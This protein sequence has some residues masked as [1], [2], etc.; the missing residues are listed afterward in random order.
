MRRISKFAFPIKR[1]LYAT[2]T[3]KQR[4]VPKTLEEKLEPLTKYF[5]HKPVPGQPLQLTKSQLV[6]LL[7]TTDHKEEVAL[8]AYANTVTEKFYGKKIFFRGIIELSNVCQKNCLYCGIR[9]SMKVHRYTMT[10]E[11]IIEQAMWAYE[12]KYGSIVLQSGELNTPQRLDMII[13]IIKELKQ[14]TGSEPGK[15]LGISLSLGEMSKEDYQRLYDAGAHRYLLRIETSNPELYAKL[16]PDDGKHL[17]T[18]RKQSLMY[19]KEIGYQVGT[20]VM[21]M[22]PGQTI[23]DLAND[24]LFFK[25]MDIDMIG[26][27]PYICQHDTPI[28]K[29]WLEQN[30]NVNMKEYNKRLFRMSLKMIAL[31]RIMLPDVNIAATTAL[32]AINPTG[33][34]IAFNSGANM[35]MPILTPK[36]YRVD[37]QLYEG[38]PCVD[39]TEEECKNCLATRIKYAGK[40]LRLDG[41]W[42]DPLHAKDRTRVWSN[43]LCTQ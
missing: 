19:L 42:G 36:K 6:D 25:D 32:Q 43:P 37:Y 29:L 10:K 9:K 30:K 14:R 3:V 20:G 7:S 18:K 12:N 27:G 24:I 41:T 4:Y 39:D 23:E 35:V 31:S 1:R 38:K 34:E 21:I 5:K 2:Q 26:M 8:F 11:E 22:I 40:D 15:G 17:W 28:G 33:R 13:E 16:H